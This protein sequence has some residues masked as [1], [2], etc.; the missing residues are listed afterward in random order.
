MKFASSYRDAE[1]LSSGYV[2]TC[3]RRFLPCRTTVFRDASSQSPL[4]YLSSTTHS[5][6]STP[7]LNS[8]SNDVPLAIGVPSRV[9]VPSQASAI[10]NRN[11]GAAQL[12]CKLITPDLTSGPKVYPNRHPVITEKIFPRS[13]LRTRKPTSSRLL[14]WNSD[15]LYLARYLEVR[16]GMGVT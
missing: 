7:R 15:C 11:R 4:A 6:R 13:A 5:L 9:A 10:Q 12:D 3:Q 8:R 16:C 2:T 14:P 1:S